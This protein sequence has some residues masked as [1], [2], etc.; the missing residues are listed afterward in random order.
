[1][2][3]YPAVGSACLAECNRIIVNKVADGLKLTPV[4]QEGILYMR[5]A[6]RA[7]NSRRN[8]RLNSCSS[9]V[10]YELLALEHRMLLSTGMV[11]TPLA[12]FGTVGDGN[13]NNGDELGGIVFYDNHN[14][15][16]PG[17][18]TPGQK[19][20]DDDGIPYV[21][22]DIR[23]K[24]SGTN[25]DVVTN[26]GS[27]PTLPIGGYLFSD[28]PDD[29]Y[30]ITVVPPPTYMV[31]P[32]GT[33]GNIFVNNVFSQ[34]TNSVTV[35]VNGDDDFNNRENCG[36]F[37]STDVP[38]FIGGMV[39]N[40][41]NADGLLD[42]NEKGIGGVIVNLLNA[43]GTPTGIPFATTG[44]GQMGTIVGA[45][46]FPTA[47]L[48]PTTAGAPSITIGNSY[49]VQFT[50]PGNFAF[51][52][53]KEVNNSP[54]IFSWVD[55]TTV[56][57]DPLLIQRRN[58][59]TA[60]AG[61]TAPNPTDTSL[62][63]V[64]CGFYNLTVTLKG[65]LNGVAGPDPNDPNTNGIPRPLTGTAPALFSVTITPLVPV[66]EFVPWTT[67]DGTLRAS[68]DGTA[69]LGE[70]IDPATA[71]VDYTAA[72]GVFEF[73]VSKQPEAKLI[74][75]SVLGFIDVV[76]DR[77]FQVSIT[78]PAGF[79]TVPTPPVVN[80]VILNTS[81]AQAT[82]G[83]FSAIR[84]TTTTTDFPFDV[85]LSAPTG[86]VGT[87]AGAPFNTYIAYT[88][89]DFSAK[90]PVDYQT[91]TSIT[92]PPSEVDEVVLAPDTLFEAN[93]I[94][95]PVTPGID[96]ELPKQFHVLVAIPVSNTSTIGTPIFGTGTI[97]P[98]TLPELSVAGSSVTENL[99]GLAQLPFTVTLDPALP[100]AVTVNYATSDGTAV[101][102]L[103]YIDTSGTLTFAPGQVTQTIF[104]PVYRRF[105][106]A[107]DKT[108]NM[109]ISTPTADI[110]VTT[111][112]AVGTIQD[113][114]LVAL[115]FSNNKKATYTDY[116]T[117]PVSVQLSGPGTGNV[118]F[119][120][121]TSVNTNA[122][123]ILV[124]GA[125]SATTLSV[126]VRKSHQTSF[127]NILV[128]SSI[129]S[130][131]AKTSNVLGLIT[132]SGSLNNLA[133]NYMAGVNLTVGAGTG[134]LSLNLGQSVGTTITSAIPISSLTALAFL[135][136]ST[137]PVDLTAPSVGKIN[138][139]GAFS[140]TTVQADSIGPVTVSGAITGVSL[141][142]TDSL[143][144]IVAKGIANSIFFAGM[145]TTLTTLPTA[146]T[147]FANKSASIVSVKTTMAGG[148]SNSLIAAWSIGT[149]NLGKIATNN[150]GT[151]F[152]VSGDQIASVIGLG[153]APIHLVNVNDLTAPLIQGDFNVRPF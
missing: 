22:V 134:S 129:G 26:N 66:T 148:F 128:T 30:T 20:P 127:Q 135:S 90:Q 12:Q 110:N 73:D 102:G 31:G 15:D 139:K 133:L 52:S 45:Y 11:A 36:M 3:K 54:T 14:A 105:L 108:V 28:L 140:S 23:G 141:L 153:T 146:S 101:A 131:M 44:N 93:A 82:I 72:S 118:V 50:M 8:L 2:L 94:E 48:L 98:N 59:V 46:S 38:P 24:N 138:I 1:V 56:E 143:G 40:D 104:V 60:P 136:S 51:V 145:S 106:A 37:T 89:A 109:T 47:V 57:T 62:T 34:T 149:V 27:D 103:D 29:T 91:T 121:T 144:P 142:A 115:P 120:G 77:R 53:N 16:A 7:K 18:G 25:Q 147:D 111:P 19:T 6:L 41:A 5:R 32:L 67:I 100:T 81:F 107:Q 21:E 96:P 95:V 87:F 9:S 97:E 79:L 113:L 64:N 125:T 124:D 70:E 78:P 117:D 68:P 112:T 83:D 88:T 71:G 130:I 13:N 42:N 43:D 85:T 150:G 33:S 58:F 80:C 74:T 17:V 99:L 151:P 114:A 4:R 75:I 132:I 123:E 119:I 152:G 92:T 61:T 69:N 55:T 63:D 65:P 126:I 137:T 122:F 35:T 84:P 10:A 116:L 86:F 76:N 39:F 49:I